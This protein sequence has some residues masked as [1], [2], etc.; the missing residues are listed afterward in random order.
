MKNVPEYHVTYVPTSTLVSH[1]PPPS[2]T[3]S[4]SCVLSPFNVTITQHSL[5]RM[6]IGEVLHTMPTVGF[7]VEQVKHRNIEFTIWDVGGQDKIRALWKYYYQGTDGLVFLVDS[8]DTDRME[9]AAEEL[10]HLLGQD[11]L[12]DAVM[13][14]CWCWPTSRTCPTRWRSVTLRASLGWARCGTGGGVCR[15]AVPPRVRGCWRALIGWLTK[16]ASN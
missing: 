13:P 7:N 2:S 10:T 5:Y 6:K 4:L 3:L 16:S 11:E 8:N 12:R 15:R 14:W 9:L 1:S